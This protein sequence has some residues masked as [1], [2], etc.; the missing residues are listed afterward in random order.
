MEMFPN[1]DRDIV[2]TALMEMEGDLDQTV[3]GRITVKDIGWA[4]T[5]RAKHAKSRGSGGMPPP[6][7]F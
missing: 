6:V 5:K 3:Q 7:Y 2:A 4:R 1:E